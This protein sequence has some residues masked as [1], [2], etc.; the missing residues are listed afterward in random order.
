MP[1]GLNLGHLGD[2][3]PYSMNCLTYPK[4]RHS[5]HGYTKCQQDSLLFFLHLTISDSHSQFQCYTSLRIEAKLSDCVYSCPNPREHVL[6]LNALT[7]D[8]GKY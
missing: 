4:N 3:Y 5:Y 6:V 1:L 7:T 2:K 8:L